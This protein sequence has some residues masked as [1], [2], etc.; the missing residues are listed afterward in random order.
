MKSCGC[1]NVLSKS[2]SLEQAPSLKV[3]WSS[4]C[5]KQCLTWVTR[6]YF[7]G[8]PYHTH[9][10]PYASTMGMGIDG[11]G[12]GYGYGYGY[13]IHGLEYRLLASSNLF[14]LNNITMQLQTSHCQ[15]IVLC[16]F[17]YLL[18]IRQRCSCLQIIQFDEIQLTPLPE[19][20]KST[21]VRATV[22]SGAELA[23]DPKL[24]IFTE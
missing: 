11:L 17:G 6:R 4:K 14:I 23:G 18:G 24:D 10:Y 16:P 1:S 19:T 15:T 2:I 7:W 5:A 9:L 20:K 21:C 12:I 13:L 8:H 3:K 22:G